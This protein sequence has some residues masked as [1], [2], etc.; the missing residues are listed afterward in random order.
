MLRKYVRGTIGE[1]STF[2]RSTYDFFKSARR[3][4]F[5]VS[6]V[7]ALDFC[8]FPF[9]MEMRAC[10]FPLRHL[11]PGSRNK[12]LDVSPDG[13]FLRAQK[14][15]YRKFGRLARQMPTDKLRA[16]LCFFLVNRLFGTFEAI[17]YLQSK[18]ITT[19]GFVTKKRNK[20][21]SQHDWLAN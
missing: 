5:K 1:T 13:R 4:N 17:S 2:R 16:S 11:R 12:V 20:E 21:P 10:L 15:S 7:L 9:G 18:E 6:F 14:I 8:Y 19:L 3:Q